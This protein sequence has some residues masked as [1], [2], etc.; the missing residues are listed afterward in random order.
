MG[1]RELS[2]KDMAVFAAEGRRSARAASPL[3]YRVCGSTQKM[4]GTLLLML[5]EGYE[6]I[7]P[8]RAVMDAEVN[9]S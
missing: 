2:L 8:S 3:P 6:A 5:L 1:V 4:L 7:G 9:T